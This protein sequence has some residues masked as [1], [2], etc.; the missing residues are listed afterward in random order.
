MKEERARCLAELPP[1]QL[2][3]S[4]LSHLSLRQES[5][6]VYW[7]RWGNAETPAPLCKFCWSRRMCTVTSSNSSASCRGTHVTTAA[8][9]PVSTKFSVLVAAI[10][11]V[12]ALGLPPAG[13]TGMLVRCLLNALALWPCM[14]HMLQREAIKHFVSAYPSAS[15]SIFFQ[16]F[17]T[18]SL[19]YQPRLFLF[20]AAEG[21][22]V[23]L[24]GWL[25]FP[26]LG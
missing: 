22:L 1:N 25:W 17:L 4:S 19:H 9:Q 3:V 12:S 10:G 15:F 13:S 18:D 20:T 8:G 16:L 14:L 26:S 24:V 23:W 21:C 11:V 5:Y 2:I 7:K 6:W